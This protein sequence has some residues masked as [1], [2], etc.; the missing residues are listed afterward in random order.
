M[1]DETRKTG[2]TEGSGGGGGLLLYDVGS[3]YG[4][5]QQLNKCKH[6]TFGHLLRMAATGL[7]STAVAV[8]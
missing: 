4:A 2:T 6:A 5:G 3:G 7:S 1:P 8:T